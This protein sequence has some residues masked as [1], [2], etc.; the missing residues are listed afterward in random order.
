MRFKR[1]EGFITWETFKAAVDYIS[2]HRF[3]Q[4]TRKRNLMNINK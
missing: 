3:Q 2:I 4:H 1:R